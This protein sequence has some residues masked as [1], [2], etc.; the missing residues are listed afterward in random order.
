MYFETSKCCIIPLWHSLNP[1]GKIMDYTI[2]IANYNGK[3]LLD[4]CLS[5]L[6]TQ[7]KDRS[8][9]V[10]VDN[11]SVDGSND[12]MRRNW[13]GVTTLLMD[14]NTGFTGANNAGAALSDSEII[15]LLN[16]DTRAASNWLEKLLIPLQDPS[17]GA[18][19]SSMRRMGDLSVMDSAGGFLDS[20]GYAFDR[21]RGEPASK[22]QVADEILFPC[23]GA[24]A[25][26]RSALEDGHTIF[27]KTLF[28]YN[29]DTDL[30]LRLWKNGYRVVYQPEAVVEHAFSATA[31]KSSTL[32]THYCTRNRVL[33]LKRHMGPEFSR[34]S[35]TLALWEA[36]I[37]GFML[38]NG[39]F[40][41]FSI[42]LSAAREGFSTRVK[43]YGKSMKAMELYAR[44]MQPTKGSY[45][46]RKI[47]ASLHKRIN[48]SGF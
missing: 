11:G 47:G 33:I 18:V 6:V 1:L 21:G 34:I 7:V 44:F 24:M 8:R 41:R 36:M 38:A 25:V 15:V 39:Q 32:K 2:I 13:P 45:I 23:G 5:S 35:S 10:V 26:R 22:W 20:L 37:L 27:W 28:L 31:G 46:R 14:S 29:E 30:G 9:I 48:S 12:H 16:N 40:R 4:T 17:V 42:S 19:T 3:H 43:P